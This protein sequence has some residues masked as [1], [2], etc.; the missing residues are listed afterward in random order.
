MRNCGQHYSYVTAN[1]MYDVVSLPIQMMFPCFP[2]LPFL[3]LE[4]W[5]CVFRSCDF[6]PCDLVPRFPVLPFPAMRFGPTFSSSTF[7]IPAF[8]VAYIG[9]KSRTERPRKTKIGT[10]ISH[11]ARDADTTFK[12]KWSKVKVTRPLYSARP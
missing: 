12:V 5:Y 1:Y 6:H 4:F 9:P 3:P 11:V 2:V 10:E 8:S 7:S